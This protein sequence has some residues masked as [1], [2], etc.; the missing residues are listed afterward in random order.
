MVVSRSKVDWVVISRCVDY[1]SFNIAVSYNLPGREPCP[2][3]YCSDEP[4]DQTKCDITVFVKP[5]ALAVI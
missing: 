3:G 1:G 2:Y 4:K 5:I